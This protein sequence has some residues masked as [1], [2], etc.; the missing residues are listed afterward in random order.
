M[1][2]VGEAISLAVPWTNS[3]RRQH[4][5]DISCPPFTLTPFSVVDAARCF[6]ESNTD[7]TDDTKLLDPKSLKISLVRVNAPHYLTYLSDFPPDSRIPYSYP[8]LYDQILFPN[9]LR[10]RPSG[11]HCFRSIHQRG[12][13]RNERRCLEPD[14]TICWQNSITYILDP[15]TQLKNAMRRLGHEG[16]L[17]KRIAE[18]PEIISLSFAGNAFSSALPTG[19]IPGWDERRRGLEGARIDKWIDQSLAP[20]GLFA[21]Y[22]EFERGL[23]SSTQ[24]NF[25]DIRVREW[26]EEEVADTGTHLDM[27][28]ISRTYR[29][30]SPCTHHRYE[31]DWTSRQGLSIPETVRQR[32]QTAVARILMKGGDPVARVKE[33]DGG[34]LLELSK[35][36]WFQLWEKRRKA[37][38]E[39]TS[40]QTIK[41]K[42]RA[43][44]K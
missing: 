34:E 40:F 41:R 39:A 3:L 29:V 31:T 18:I 6:L 4:N 44:G 14:V 19:T 32:I 10:R 20:E 33:I 13:R 42:P 2:A 38:L 22:E 23:L 30:G 5:L 28:I 43:R 37:S 12:T 7:I 11:V 35:P 36:D 15:K 24:V 26:T 25:D 16:D 21:S 27:Q 9:E 17:F 8:S 1:K